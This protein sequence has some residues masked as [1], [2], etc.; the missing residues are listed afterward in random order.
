MA[1]LEIVEFPNPGLKENC[2]E[3]TEVTDEIK[4]L[5]EDMAETMYDAP[6]V[7]LA[8][9]QIG[10]QKRIIV[11]DPGPKNPED[12]NETGELYKLVNPEIIKSEGQV[13]SEEGCLSIP[14]IK[15]TI[16]RSQRVVVKALNE[17]GE[18]INIDADGFLAIVLQHEIDHLN[19]V[20]FID[21]LSRLKQKLV[22]AKIKKANRDA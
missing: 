19:G 9:P 10:I 15:E 7:G 20:L 8:A 1:L 16:K 22:K 6:G 21:H 11:V 4:T 14:G 12:E 5:L 18:E 3:V 17:D 13:D 2:A